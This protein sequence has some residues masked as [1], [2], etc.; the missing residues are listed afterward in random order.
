MKVILP[1]AILIATISTHIFLTSKPAPEPNKQ[2]PK[3]N[4]NSTSS[5]VENK[6]VFINAKFSIYTLGTKR[7]FS[8]PMYQNLSEKAYIATGKG[9]QIIA[10]NSTT[11]KE[12]FDT[13]PFSLD[14]QCLVTGTKQRFCTNTT[15]GLNFY[16]NG[17]ID[18]EALSRSINEG[19]ELEVRFE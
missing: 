18:P 1:I 19:D 13:L 6:E 11:W 10:L 12:F 17:A 5:E 16:L 3:T 7:D 8:N 9:D 14:T 4:N 2:T 15:Q